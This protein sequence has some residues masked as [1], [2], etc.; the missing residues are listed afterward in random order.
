M[1]HYR[2]YESYY[3][4][5]ASIYALVCG[6]QLVGLMLWTLMNSINNRNLRKVGSDRIN[7]T[8]FWF[9]LLYALNPFSS[10]I[11][12]PSYIKANGENRPFWNMEVMMWRKPNQILRNVENIYKKISSYM[13]PI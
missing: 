4:I 10:V 12:L 7:K 2:D 9:I 6:M 13:L 8:N 5:F 1:N 11:M 3:E